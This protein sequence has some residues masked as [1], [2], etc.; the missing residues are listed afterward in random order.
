M[1]MSVSPQD[2]A[3]D[4]V[5]L[6]P[7]DVVEPGTIVDGSSWYYWAPPGQAEVEWDKTTPR[8]PLALAA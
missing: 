1:N 5:R 7:A 3:R 6:V 8:V 4:V 2:G